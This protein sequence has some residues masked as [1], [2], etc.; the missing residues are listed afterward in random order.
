MMMGSYPSGFLSPNELF[1][2]QVAL[3]IGFYH[4]NR[5]MT[6]KPALV[7]TGYFL[8]THPRLTL[9]F[10]TSISSSFNPLNGFLNVSFLIKLLWLTHLPYSR[11]LISHQYVSC[12][13]HFDN[14]FY[15]Q[16]TSNLPHLLDPAE[17]H[18]NV[19]KDYGCTWWTPLGYPRPCM[20]QS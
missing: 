9:S 8:D 14:T 10:L 7:T 4:S 5:K 11:A 16:K 17:D 1:L 18:E 3:V 20:E 2:L 15:P 6:N 12:L 19:P 13:F